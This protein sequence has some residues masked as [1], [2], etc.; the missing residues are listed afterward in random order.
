MRVHS[1]RFITVAVIVTVAVALFFQ[2]WMLVQG[3]QRALDLM[4]LRAAN[5]AQATAHQVQ[6][7]IKQADLLLLDLR[8][9]LDPQEIQRGPNV[10]SA[11]KAG[12]MRDLLRLHMAEAPHL[13]SVGI[14]AP[15]G[16]TVYSSFNSTSNISFANRRF[17]QE[18]Q[19]ARDDRFQV[20]EPLKGHVSERWGINV[21]RRLVA[22]DGRFA[23]VLVAV[24]DL[25]SLGAAMM[26]VDRQ[27]WI[28]ALYDD[29]LRLAARSPSLPAGMGESIGQESHD[30]ILRSWVT[31]RRL[32]FQR[33]GL[34][35]EQPQIWAI[36]PI[37]GLPLLTVAGFSRQRALAQWRKDL[38]LNLAVAALLVGGCIGILFL[39]RQKDLAHR[40]LHSREAY[41]RTLFD[42]SPEAIA[43]VRWHGTS[44]EVVD[45]NIRYRELFQIQQGNGQ[46][47]WALAPSQQPDGALSLERGQRLCELSRSGLIQRTPWQCLR[48]DGSGFDAEL[49]VM[50][51]EHE[52]HERIITVVRDLTEIHAMEEKLHQA[53]KLDALGQLAGGVAHD[54][55]NMLAVILASAEMLMD[56][57]VED[58]Q[59]LLSKTIIS[60]SERAGQLTKKLL[61]FARK[62]KILSTAT[63]VHQIVLETVALLERT[64][65]P[66]ISIVTR[67]EAAPSTVIGDPSQIQNALLN[68]GV[69]ARDAMPGGGRIMIASDTFVVDE[70]GR[71]VG[72]F[73]LEPGD[74]LH[75]SVADTG[76]GIPEVHL[77]RIFDPFFTTKD[78]GKGTGLGLAAVFGAMASHKG[79]VT[80]ES[81][82]NEG[83]TFH[84]YLPLGGADVRRTPVVTAP[85][86]GNGMLLVVDDEDLVRTSIA[87][88]LES[89]GHTVL[90]EG[91]AHHAVDAFRECH[92]RLAGVLVDL[93]MPGISGRDV[94]LEMHGINPSV[95]IILMSGFPRNA[96]IGELMDAGLKGFLQKP[97]NRGEL[98]ELLKN[99]CVKPP[100]AA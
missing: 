29:H 97:F 41:F 83:S 40:V 15:D 91:D 81:R 74:Y 54:F 95:P 21:T 90:S 56:N 88:M 20:S 32:S 98:A 76:C 47:P 7:L 37:E 10:E 72:A 68:L 22:S 82:I 23:G 78:V 36:Q 75:L 63:D 50:A 24:L 26:A 31:D 38:H 92:G 51:F 93:V 71:Q 2:G 33:S 80:V 61:A 62:G 64:I 49:T 46:P 48:A 65:D 66:R 11:R 42:A 30:P 94:A 70:A 44:G 85:P 18:Q 6:G 53:Q 14:I 55:N 3:Y 100:S 5:R 67:L 16:R 89:L 35:E 13:L 84:L 9:H 39:Q 34:G 27:Q 69:N 58:H 17:F 60:A 57:V 4:S 1:P 59:R 28:L 8:G 87:M 99:V 86:R 43:V 45:S 79:A 77:Q 96:K 19:N 73:H 12:S 52:S 25:E